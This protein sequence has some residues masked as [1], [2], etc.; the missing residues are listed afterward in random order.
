[1]APKYLEPLGQYSLSIAGKSKSPSHDTVTEH[2]LNEAAA[3]SLFVEVEGTAEGKGKNHT[4]QIL[5]T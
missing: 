1:M 3:Y 4:G 5:I 2:E